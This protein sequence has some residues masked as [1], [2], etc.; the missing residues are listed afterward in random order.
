MAG[1]IIQ[2]HVGLVSHYWDRGENAVWRSSSRLP[3][4]LVRKIKDDYPLLMVGRPSS[5][6][7]GDFEV[8]FEYGEELD[9]F[10]RPAPSFYAAVYPYGDDATRLDAVRDF[11]FPASAETPTDIRFEHAAPAGGKVV[12]RR[13]RTTANSGRTAPP[14]KGRAGIS[15]K[16][17]AAG[18]ILICAAL[19]AAYLISQY[20]IPKDTP[21]ADEIQAVEQSGAAIERVMSDV[22]AP[23]N[24]CEQLESAPSARTPANCARQ[25]AKIYCAAPESFRTGSSAAALGALGYC[26]A[27]ARLEDNARDQ[28]LIA[29]IDASDDLPTW[30][31]QFLREDLLELP[32]TTSRRGEAQ[33]STG[34][35]ERPIPKAKKRIKNVEK[36][37][38]LAGMGLKNRQDRATQ[39]EKRVLNDWNAAIELSGFERHRI[40]KDDEVVSSVNAYIDTY[41]QTSRA[42]KSLE[43]D[44]ARYS[45]SDPLLAG[46]KEKLQSNPIELS[47]QLELCR[48]DGKSSSFQGAEL[49][50]WIHDQQVVSNLVAV[51]D[52]C[53]LVDFDRLSDR[54]VTPLVRSCEDAAMVLGVSW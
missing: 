29:D 37:D 7:Y 54:R 22:A 18:T 21:V 43:Q 31:R 33:I 15:V 45:F 35:Y 3:P 10:G 1:K 16:L 34:G 50:A 30:S 27:Y 38:G 25:R 14:V 24:F 19:A 44:Y 13:S 4:D 49:A 9:K 12:I 11:V 47:L 46:V 53:T 20:S 41:C 36:P 40:I 5:R 2:L 48:A 39:A 17:I 28:A 42:L 23:S 6:R 51:V 52:F 8:A 32:S 26:G